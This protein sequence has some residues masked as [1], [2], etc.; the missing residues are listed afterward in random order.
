MRGTTRRSVLLAAAGGL[1]AVMGSASKSEPQTPQD[2]DSH[3]HSSRPISGLLAEATVIFGQWPAD[4]T[5]NRMTV[6]NPGNRNTHLII[7]NEVTIQAGGTVNFVVAGVHQ[8]VIYDDGTQKDDIKSALG[9][10]APLANLINDP[11]RRIYVG[12]SPFGVP[13]DFF[14]P[15]MP[16]AAIPVPPQ[17]RTEAV[18]FPNPGRYLVICAV[19]GHFADGMFG[20]V[21]VL[22]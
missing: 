15:G 10:P 18:V 3:D 9:Y 20:F 21:R 8:I 14:G 1:T 17:D 2:A 19:R 7:P 11:A 22:P 16:S 4:S 5:V 13:V 6:A 12:L